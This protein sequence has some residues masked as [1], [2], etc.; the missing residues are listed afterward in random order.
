MQSDVREI[1][2]DRYGKIANSNTGC[3]GG[4]NC[5]GDQAQAMGYTED[6][7]HTAPD[8]ANLG[9]GCGNPLA[10]EII[11]SGDTVLDLGS[12]AGFDCFLA[13]RDTGP[14]GRVIGVDMTPDMIR[15][16]EENRVKA[17]LPNVEFR[18][19]YIED[20]PVDSNSVEV[21]IS[22]C[23]IN[24]S[25]DKPQVFREAFRVLKPGGTL[26]VSDIVLNRKLP[27]VV[28]NRIDAYV[29]CIG[30]AALKKDYLQLIRQVGF[31][32]VKL[33]NEVTVDSVFSGNDVTYSSFIKRIPLPKKYVKQQSGKYAASVTLSAKKPVKTEI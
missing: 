33:L 1:V 17:G 27:W 18:Q 22:N 16:A 20:L 23:V 11:Q 3:C 6:Q 21:V 30:G 2:K 9:L 29:G 10:G 19:G 15:Q 12:G 26:V 5:G 4:S 25:P 7:I 31:N 24:L 32:P 13:A 28:R 14:Q 8:G